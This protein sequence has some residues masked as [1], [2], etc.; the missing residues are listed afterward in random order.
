MRTESTTQDNGAPVGAQRPPRRKGVRAIPPH[1]K[2]SRRLYDLAVKDANRA[3]WAYTRHAEQLQ[4]ALDD[5]R[6]ALEAMQRAAYAIADVV[7]D[8]A[9]GG[10]HAA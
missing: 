5:W 9:T 3:R 7:Y 1:V 10:D 6:H 8:D 4:T 2:A